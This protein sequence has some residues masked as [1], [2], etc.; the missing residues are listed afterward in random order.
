VVLANDNTT[1]LGAK[2]EG[3]AVGTNL[4]LVG[5]RYDNEPRKLGDKCAG[6][7]ALTQSGA[8]EVAANIT[9]SR[10]MT[11][12][13]AVCQ[14]NLQVE[15]VLNAITVN[16][17]RS[18][19]KFN[20]GASAKVSG[21]SAQALIESGTVNNGR[22]WLQSAHRGGY[23]ADNGVVVRFDTTF[24]SPNANNNQ[25]AGV[26]DAENGFFFGYKGDTFGIFH[27]YAAVRA[28]YRMKLISTGTNSK[29]TI[30][31]GGKEQTFTFAGS[32]SAESYLERF[33]ADDAYFRD[34]PD[35]GWDIY[36]AKIGDV[37]YVRF[38]SV[39]A[40]VVSEDD[41]PEIS[42]LNNTKS[43]LTC[44]R[45][46]GVGGVGGD[47][48]DVFI[49]Q[50]DWNINKL[51]NDDQ[52]NPTTSNYVYQIRYQKNGKGR[53]VFYIENRSTGELMPVHQIESAQLTNAVLPL[54][55]ESR[56]GASG[57][58]NV[59]ISTSGGLIYSESAYVK[60][61]GVY[62]SINS[63]RS[64]SIK[65]A[66]TNLILAVLNS[67]YVDGI[68]NCGLLKLVRMSVGITLGNGSWGAVLR[69]HDKVGNYIKSYDPTPRQ[70][71]SSNGGVIEAHTMNDDGP[72]VVKLSASSG[73]LASFMYGVNGSYNI[74]M[75]PY[76][77]QVF[78][79]G[80]IEFT[81]E[82]S[83]NNNMILLGTVWQYIS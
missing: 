9:H 36:Y 83:G 31:A 80:T 34:S 21:D 47:G 17:P 73:E 11:G 72:R 8:V 78:G 29:F 22:A 30:S 44:E 48:G 10:T 57:D 67:P 46:G 55:W 61:V 24:G 3:V 19:V 74:D 32:T 70:F 28:V 6:A 62:T 60:N 77:I 40:G 26:G 42:V 54:M 25:T 15:L 27:R 18:V 65:D 64:D 33:V 82:T 43:T 13:L 66:G 75:L 16:Q 1:T 38:I 12:E 49:S 56:N 79:G 5:G 81:V 23:G 41:A 4:L 14:S 45:V 59:Q 68:I 7:I 69:I 51:L 2:T 71:L 53:V 50:S 58:T 52:F 35:G 39:S 63:F 76:N 37:S 20:Y